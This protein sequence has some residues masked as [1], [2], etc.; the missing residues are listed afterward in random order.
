MA[1]VGISMAKTHKSPWFKP[2][3]RGGQPLEI[4]LWA[5]ESGKEWMREKL[6]WVGGERRKFGW[7]MKEEKLY[8]GMK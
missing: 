2:Q 5:S 4:V 3:R 7:L 6:G 1:F 8:A